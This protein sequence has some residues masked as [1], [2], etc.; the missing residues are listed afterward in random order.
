MAGIKPWEKHLKWVPIDWS[1]DQLLQLHKI[2]M[3]TSAFKAVGAFMFLCSADKWLE[4]TAPL[5][6]EKGELFLTKSHQFFVRKGTGRSKKF[7]LVFLPPFL[8]KLFKLNER[9]GGKLKSSLFYFHQIA[10]SKKKERKYGNKN[11]ETNKKEDG[12]QWNMREIRVL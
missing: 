3:F 2:W 10:Q 8:T 12:S 1:F 4:F 9:F 7:I 5:D 11:I 6:G